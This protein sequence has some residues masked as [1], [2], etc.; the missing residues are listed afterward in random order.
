[1]EHVRGDGEPSEAMDHAR[2]D[3]E[4]DWMQTMLKQA[5]MLL[6]GHAHDQLNSARY[7]T[8]R[9]DASPDWPHS[10]VSGFQEEAA[11]QTP[12]DQ[13]TG[14]LKQVKG[15]LQQ[16]RVGLMHVESRL[17]L[18]AAGEAVGTSGMPLGG[19][20]PEHEPISNLREL[21]TGAN[22]W[23]LECY[24]K[25]T[26]GYPRL[27]VIR[28][29]LIAQLC[30]SL[31]HSTRLADSND[32]LSPVADLC[33]R[34]TATP[35]SRNM[36]EIQYAPAYGGL[37]DERMLSLRLAFRSVSSGQTEWRYLG[38]SAGDAATEPLRV[39]VTSEPQFWALVDF[40][41]ALSE[42]G[43]GLKVLGAA[44]VTGVLGKVASG[45]EQV[46]SSGVT[47]GAFD[48]LAAQT[49]ASGGASQAVWLA[50]GG[51]VAEP[52]AG[53]EAA[54]AEASGG[55]GAF[56]AGAASAE[57]ARAAQLW[58]PLALGLPALLQALSK[59]QSHLFR[60]CKRCTKLY[61]YSRISAA[62]RWNFEYVRFMCSDPR[63]VGLYVWGFPDATLQPG[64]H[65]SPS[66][67]GEIADIYTRGSE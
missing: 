36:W 67:Q 61:G 25:Y 58:L 4:T 35:S 21:D 30:L 18:H 1:M 60:S 5:A 39:I 47:D 2:G 45:I 13:G 46:A 62:A 12:S 24:A 34:S 64:L 17:L 22:R 28:N 51:A 29:D 42:V 8:P 63:D 26:D 6:P 48:S 9:P 57:A 10:A 14:L 15:H 55:G 44:G 11:A 3:G 49:D 52:A 43:V 56:A 66:A 31:A 53:E 54:T 23:K 19:P 32:G 40:Q 38:V 59:C 20:D 33:L 16:P 37:I 27:V 50:E 41:P 7:H 65:F